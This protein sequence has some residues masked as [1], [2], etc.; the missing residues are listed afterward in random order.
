MNLPSWYPTLRSAQDG[1]PGLVVVRI[2]CRSFALLRMK[3]HSESHNLFQVRSGTNLM[4][5]D[6]EFA[7]APVRDR[8]RDLR[9]YL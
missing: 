9:E 3:A 8:V 5:N 1:A 2:D 7:Y 4:L 6:L